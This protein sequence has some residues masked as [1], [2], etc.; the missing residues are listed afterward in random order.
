MSLSLFQHAILKN[1]VLQGID[2][3]QGLLTTTVYHFGFIFESFIVQNIPRQF[4]SKIYHLVATKLD[5]AAQ[6]DYMKGNVNSLEEKIVQKKKFNILHNSLEEK[7]QMWQKPYSSLHPKPLPI[8]FEVSKKKTRQQK[9][10]K[11]E[12]K[13][14]IIQFVKIYEKNLYWIA[15]RKLHI[16]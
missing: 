9:T 12:R 13:I 16:I 1:S 5:L 2:F 6:I 4:H 10:Q 15:S 7:I 11:N 8:P 3:Q 14:H